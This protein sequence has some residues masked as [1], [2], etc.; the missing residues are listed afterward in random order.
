[1][2]VLDWIDACRQKIAR[3]LSA[4]TG[5]LQGDDIGRAE[6]ELAL[7]AARCELKEPRLFA[8]G[9]DLKIEASAVAIAALLLANR[10]LD[11]SDL[12]LYILGI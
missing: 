9:S 11:F 6:A 4:V 2:L 10:A 3:R 7:F 1:M 8:S 12:S 5:Q